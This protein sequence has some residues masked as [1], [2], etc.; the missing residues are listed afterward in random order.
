MY[1]IQK[2]LD[3][4]F[5]EV[6]YLEKKSNNNLDS[7][8]DNAGKNNYTKYNRDYMAWG[9]GGSR[10][11]QW[12][13]AFVSWCFATAYGLEAA[14]SLLCGGL[15]HYTP[16]G[17][18]RFKK[19]NR[20][21]KRGQAAPEIGD[22]VFF[23]SSAKGRIGHVG[24]VYDVDSTHVYTVE[25][26]TS[27]AST[28]VT[29]GGGVR[30]KSYQL[31]STYIDGYGRPNYADDPKPVTPTAPAKTKHS[32]TVLEWQKAAIADGYKFP[33]YGADGKWGT[34]C[35]SVAKAAIVKY[36][37]PYTNL[38]L[39]KIVQKVVGVTADGKCGTKTDNAIKTYQA[40]NGLKA[41]GL[42]GLKT[43]KKILNKR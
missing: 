38:N 43:W 2:L 8:T 4:A 6:G 40:A 39:T 20:Y 27:G 37:K 14:K 28:L 25:G 23:Y 31:T 15:H 18:N 13:A 26:N 32:P 21:I 16:T 19:V 7:K 9:A 34:E 24:I 36:V 1:S 29:N 33:K 41:D 22:V 10:D 42:V 11:M 30:K 17:A 35:E 12:C 5:A 3:V